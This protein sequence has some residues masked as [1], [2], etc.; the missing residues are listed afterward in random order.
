MVK[1][2][3]L[4]E[5][6]ARKEGRREEQVMQ[7]MRTVLSAFRAHQMELPSSAFGA[8]PNVSAVWAKPA[9]RS[10]GGLCRG[11]MRE[12]IMRPTGAGEPGSEIT[13]ACGVQIWEGAGQEG[14][15]GGFRR[16]GAKLAEWVS[17][18]TQGDGGVHPGKG[19]GR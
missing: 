8:H 17:S 4:K 19:P 2:C 3:F 16:P 10:R 11:Q 15:A 18:L 7:E 12:D 6:M 13:G 14:E 5:A 1:R 9:D